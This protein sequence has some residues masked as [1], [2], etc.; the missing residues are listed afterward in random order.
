[1][2][3]A[4]WSPAETARQLKLSKAA[5]SQYLKGESTPRPA[6]L[7][8]LREAVLK[9][10]NFKY[11][12]KPPQDILMD[13]EKKNSNVRPI[14]LA[15][16]AHKLR[17]ALAPVI[18]TARAGEGS[19]PEDMGHASPKIAV[20]CNDPNCYVLEV[21]GDSMEP[22]YSPGDLLVVAPNI[23]PNNNDLVIVKTI[24]EEVFFKEYR[25]P[26]KGDLLQFVSLNAKYPPLYFRPD[27][28]Y[29]ISV[30]HSIIKPLKAKWKAM[31]VSESASF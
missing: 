3:A 11:E 28:L 5:I 24:E 4:G 9:A 30:V 22:L 31:T 18:A 10:A 25:I 8:A 27:Q 13:D 26:R 20:P 16:L 23:P 6:I 19:Y 15:R 7:E 21:E 17:F 29:R 12:P 1:M 2:E 14:D